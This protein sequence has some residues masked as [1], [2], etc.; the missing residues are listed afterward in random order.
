MFMYVNIYVC[1]IWILVDICIFHTCLQIYTYMI[2]NTYIFRYI[3][4]YT[5]I[6]SY[7]L[8]T[9]IYLYVYVHI[10]AVK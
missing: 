8:P 2:C 9:H 1:H 6:Y 3:S 4:I 7:I 5:Y 10:C